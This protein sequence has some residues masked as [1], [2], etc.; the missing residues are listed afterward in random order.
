MVKG[1]KR[2]KVDCEKWKREVGRMRW[3]RYRKME[4]E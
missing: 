4:V 1:K 3:V 2:E